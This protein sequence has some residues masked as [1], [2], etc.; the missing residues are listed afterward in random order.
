M[1]FNPPPNWPPTP[2][3]WTPPP[4]WEPDPEWGPPPVGWPLWLENQSWFAKHKVLTGVSSAG[5]AVAMMLCALGSVVRDPESQGLAQAPQ[6]HPAAAGAAQAAASTSPDQAAADL[7]ASAAAGRA[8]EAAAEKA[9]ADKAAAEKAAADKAAAEKAA[10]DKAATA[11]A[12]AEKAAAQ[13]AADRMVR[14]PDLVGLKLNIALDVAT[15]VGLTGVT[16]CRTPGGDIPLWWSNWRVLDQDVTA[17][18]RIRASRTVCLAAMKD[19]DM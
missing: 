17:G 3:G 14:M 2:R 19:S 18:K 7:A 6:S 11:K 4:G 9:A 16:V 12:A 15:N 1:R 5:V 13:R 10:A 8:A